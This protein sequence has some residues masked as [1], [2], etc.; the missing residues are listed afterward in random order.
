MS[1]VP[2]AT[3]TTRPRVMTMRP[4]INGSKSPASDMIPKKMI[5]KMNI[6]TTF[7][8]DDRPDEKNSWISLRPNPVNNAPITGMTT[9]AT[10]GETL[11]QMRSP[12]VTAMI[13][14]PETVSRVFGSVTDSAASRMSG[15]VTAFP[16]LQI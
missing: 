11:P 2:I 4:R 8:T 14:R 15:M 10:I 16:S 9:I 12:T 7:I 6:T 1:T 5:A 3:S 13:V